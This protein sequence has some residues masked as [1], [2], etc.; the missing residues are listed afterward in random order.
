MD[1]SYNSLINIT[2]P[3][4]TSFKLSTNRRKSIGTEYFNIT[5]RKDLRDDDWGGAGVG[6]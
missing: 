5:T 3:R 4:C 6:G 1:S 2:F